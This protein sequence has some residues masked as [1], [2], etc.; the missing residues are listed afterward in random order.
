MKRVDRG[1]SVVAVVAVV[2]LLQLGSAGVAWLGRRQVADSL[3][4]EQVQLETAQRELDRQRERALEQVAPAPKL[5]TWQ[6]LPAADVAG[7]MQALQ[8][9]GDQNGVVVEDL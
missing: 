8:Q 2:V 1:R 9:L 6:L 4:A 5:S 3:Q 7:T